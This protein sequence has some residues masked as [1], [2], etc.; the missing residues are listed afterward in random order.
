MPVSWRN[1]T[2]STL[3]HA[4]LGYAKPKGDD[5]FATW[6]LAAEHE[7]APRNV[8][9][10]ELASDTSDDKETLVHGGLRHWIK[11]NKVALDMTVG[12]WKGESESRNFVTVGMSFF[13]LR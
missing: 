11:P 3:A 6:A 5:G 13:D 4:T 1:E 10:A 7:F 9:F 8:V 12:R 2:G